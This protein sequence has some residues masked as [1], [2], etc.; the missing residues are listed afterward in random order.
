VAFSVTA[1]DSCLPGYLTV[2]AC[3][4]RPPTS[5]INYELGRTTAGMAITPLTDGT[6]CIFASTATDLVVDVMGAFTPGG[7]RFH[8]LAP[9]RWIDTRGAT[10]Q[11]PAITGARVAP[12]QTQLMVRGQGGVPADATAVWLNLTAADPT[13]PTVLAAYPGPCGSGPLSSNVNAR[14]QRSMASSALVGL[15]ADGSICV[16]SFS[17]SSH[18][19]VDVAGWFGP[20]SNGLSYRA[21][22]PRRLLDTRAAG[23]QPSN[24]DHSVAIDGVSVLNVVGVDST[25]LGFVSVKPCG[26]ALVSSLINTTPNEDTANVTAVGGDAAGNV[27]VR[28]S[29][30]SHVVVDQ[31][32]AFVP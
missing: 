25:A 16:K 20:G 1:V 14:S 5:N 8:P 18:I 24:A 10:V 32:A 22:A 26:S 19:V 12:T 30:V 7:A 17:G 27:C 15:G 29:I 23:G 4:G 21:R 3:G 6:A 13:L 2:F 31:I 11:L 28:S 9:T